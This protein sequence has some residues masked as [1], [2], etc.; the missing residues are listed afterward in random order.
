M[1]GAQDLIDDDPAVNLESRRR[2]QFDV[3]L[4]TN[5]GHYAVDGEL[6]NLAGVSVPGAE[7]HAASSLLQID[8]GMPW[9]HL[10]PLLTVGVG[11]KAGQVAG[12][13]AVADGVAGEEVDH[14]LPVRGQGGGDLRADEPAA[15]DGEPIAVVGERA[16]ASVVIERAE[17]DHPIPSDRQASRA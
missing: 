13:E 1:A 6:A 17:G 11:D 5:P 2:G 9:Q 7:D 10:D 3:R 14:L 12:E 15:D 16:Q 4:C 8:D